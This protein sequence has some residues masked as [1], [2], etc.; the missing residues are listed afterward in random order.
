[1]T[2]CVLKGLLSIIRAFG[3]LVDE[4][5]LTRAQDHIVEVVPA[6]VF[7]GRNSEIDSVALWFCVSFNYDSVGPSRN[8][9]ILDVRLHINHR[10][11]CVSRFRHM[12][13][14]Y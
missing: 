14:H 6:D 1:M 4:N 7:W 13:S 3:E 5:E 2:P 12:L 9:P 8:Y 10:P 11:N